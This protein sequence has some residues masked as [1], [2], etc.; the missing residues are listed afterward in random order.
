MKTT[1]AVFVNSAIFGAVVGTV[2]WLA[3]H[4]IGGTILLGLMGAG[5]AFAAGMTYAAE[6]N[7]DLLGDRRDARPGDGAGTEIAVV[8][9]T[10]VWPLVAA[11]AT[12]GVICGVMFAPLVAFAG[13]ALLLVAI[14]RLVLESN[15][16]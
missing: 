10:S 4:H 15:R 13:G 7:A 5:A 14:W 12:F 8:T 11:L 16:R 1:R 2:Y 6:R 9:T 3:S